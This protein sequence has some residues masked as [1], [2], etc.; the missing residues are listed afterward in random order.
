MIVA[1]IVSA[2]SVGIPVAAKDPFPI[3]NA[4][5]NMAAKNTPIGEQFPRR[6]TAIP[7]KPSLGIFP[8]S[9]RFEYPQ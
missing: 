2:S 7:S 3:F 5:K 9:I 8:I 6:A 1:M 4:P